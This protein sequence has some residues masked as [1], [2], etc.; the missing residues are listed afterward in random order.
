MIFVI[1]SIY[2]IEPLKAS[3]RFCNSLFCNYGIFQ[4]TLTF[5]YLTYN[6]FTY[7]KCQKYR[8]SRF[9]I[10]DMLVVKFYL[11]YLIY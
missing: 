8:I 2:H 1:R 10:L 3:L 11:N 9:S 6:K 7:E 4:F 5:G